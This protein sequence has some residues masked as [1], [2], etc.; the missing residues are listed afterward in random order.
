MRSKINSIAQEGVE[1]V[2]ILGGGLNFGS[3]AIVGTTP[4]LEVG[5]DGTRQTG[6]AEVRTK[7]NS[8]LWNAYGNL[9]SYGQQFSIYTSEIITDLSAVELSNFLRGRLCEREHFSESCASRSRV[10]I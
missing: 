1:V 8:S 2:D 10:Y 7:I 3:V 6:Q 5:S 4:S 9:Q